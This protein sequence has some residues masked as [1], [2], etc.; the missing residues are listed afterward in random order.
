MCI[1]FV[2]MQNKT[3]SPFGCWQ[4]SHCLHFTLNIHFWFT[5]TNTKSAVV[6]S[7]RSYLSDEEALTWHLPLLRLRAAWATRGS[8]ELWFCSKVE[9][10][11]T[12]CFA[13]E[14][15]V[16]SVHVNYSC[17]VCLEVV[18]VLPSSFHCS[19]STSLSSPL[20]VS[21]P[22]G[23]GVKPMTAP[24]SVITPMASI[25]GWRP[26][27]FALSHI[28]FCFFPVL[29]ISIICKAPPTEISAR[30]KEASALSAMRGGG[31]SLLRSP[32]SCLH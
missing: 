23:V 4:T 16:C 17:C 18:S 20:S 25:F 32:H 7:S 31:G 28:I 6:S 3:N 21:T 8:H 22:A 2:V 15:G 1:A 12:W 19:F 10:V 14:T 5:C 30:G 26:L 29:L 13:A 11:H 27:S 9:N 24:L